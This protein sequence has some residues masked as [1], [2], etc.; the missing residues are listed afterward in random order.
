MSFPVLSTKRLNLIEIKEEHVA[1]IYSIFS[2]EEVI[3]YY[4][5]SPL[6]SIDQAATML[7]SF[8]NGFEQKRSMRWGIVWKETG[9]LLGTVGLNNLS[10]TS[11]RTEI[12]YDLLPA[13]WRKGIVTEAVE[14]V[15]AYCFNELKLYRIGAVTFP[16]NEASFT[17]LLKLGFEKEGVL[18]GYLYQDNESHDAFIFSLTQPDWKL[19]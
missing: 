18:K 6:T 17:L 13:H 14:A 19:R 2:N 12:G 15:I 9:E 11:K 7:K 4:G 8:A 3:Q 5:M 1:S 16:Q 10:F